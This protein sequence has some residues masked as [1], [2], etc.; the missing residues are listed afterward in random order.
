[1]MKEERVLVVEDEIVIAANM[2]ETLQNLGY[3]NIVCVYTAEDALI[4]LKHNNFDVV[5][6]DVKLGRGIDGIDVVEEIRKVKDLR[7]IYVTGN[8]DDET[9]NKAKR[10]LPSG[11]LTKPVTE[12]N[13]KIQ[14]ELLLFKNKM[15]KD[16]ISEHQEVKN[17]YEGDISELEIT[18]YSDGTIIS[19]S[20]VIRKVTGVA[21]YKY[22]G[23]NIATAGLG[24]DIYNLLNDGL[25]NAISSEKHITY[26]KIFS[27]FLG[28]RLVLM[29]SNA[30]TK[31]IVEFLFTDI[32]SSGDSNSTLVN[33]AVATENTDI[34]RGVKGLTSVA[35]NLHIS[36]VI[37]DSTSLQ[38]YLQSCNDGIVLAD[39]KLHG[40]R[41]ILLQH[42]SKSNC[43]I[44]LM[45]SPL[46]EHELLTSIEPFV[47]DGYISK[48]ASD[49]TFLEMI[50]SVKNSGKYYDPCLDKVLN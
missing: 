40:L 8:S 16:E 11:F 38:E 37:T 31:H 45:A 9:V 27:P 22:S 13:L 14:M 1:M 41:N 33:I 49:A 25:K 50:S 12:H 46:L 21:G 15:I 43:K 47:F 36:G 19:A 48:V 29:Q 32:T 28:E 3:T 26:G 30:K 17:I 20:P 35:P 18:L 44:I 42:R 39:V 2:E 5:L 10:T 23:T 34:L 6:M 7:V 4:A 24:S